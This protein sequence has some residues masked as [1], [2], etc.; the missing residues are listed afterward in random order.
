[1]VA[2]SVRDVQRLLVRAELDAVRPADVSGELLQL[3]VGR[4]V[5]NSRLHGRLTCLRTRA[6]IG[7]IHTTALVDN[8]IV[9]P[10][11]R[12]AFVGVDQHSLTTRR[13]EHGDS[14]LGGLYRDQLT[15][16]IE[17]KAVGTVGA[18]EIRRRAVIGRDAGNL[19]DLRFGER[20]RAIRQRDWP[21][22]AFETFL[23]EHDGSTRRDH[24]VD[25]WS[26]Q[27]VGA[28]AERE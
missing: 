12:L 13:R 2:E 5:V 18:L 25:G 24:A 11:Q 23:D 3:A 16:R 10:I 20:H 4:Q 27:P 26:D 19:I 15:G 28:R 21:F 9:R 7:E 17:C 1:V 14:W 22:R 8:Q 6:W